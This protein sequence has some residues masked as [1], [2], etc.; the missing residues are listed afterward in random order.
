MVRMA[1]GAGHCLQDALPSLCQYCTS[2]VSVL[3]NHC[4]QQTGPPAPSAVFG[5]CMAPLQLMR[6]HQVASAAVA[7]VVTGLYGLL[8]EIR[9][10]SA[11]WRGPQAAQAR[12]W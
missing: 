7:W 9:E 2:H 8:E 5:I 11:A 10:A 12:N 4:M 3:S 6:R 1:R